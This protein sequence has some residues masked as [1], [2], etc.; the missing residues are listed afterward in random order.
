MGCMSL[1]LEHLSFCEL[2][3]AWRHTTQ[4]TCMYVGSTVFYMVLVQPFMEIIMCFGYCEIGHTQAG[5]VSPL[6]LIL[7]KEIIFE[8]AEKCVKKR[9]SISI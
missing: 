3:I 5:H 9:K 4:A 7:W 6:V 1:V 8:S 2:G